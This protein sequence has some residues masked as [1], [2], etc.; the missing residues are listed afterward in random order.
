VGHI[1]WVTPAPRSNIANKDYPCGADSFFGGQPTTTIAPGTYTLHWEEFIN[2]DGSPFRIALSIGSDDNYEEHILVDHLPHMDVSGYT[3][4]YFN[5]TIPNINCPRC[6]LQLVNPMTDKI[7]SGSCCE[8][9]TATVN[10]VCFSVYHSCANIVITGTQD[11]A[12]WTPPA[13]QRGPYGRESTQWTNMGNLNYKLTAP[14]TVVSNPETCPGSD[15]GSSASLS[16]FLLSLLVSLLY[17][18]C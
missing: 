8:Y 17:F 5:I 10:P 1:R 2:H 12:T 15:L 4:Y 3:Q 11:P 9:P 13:T 16:T 7:S 14:Y 6:G 18:L